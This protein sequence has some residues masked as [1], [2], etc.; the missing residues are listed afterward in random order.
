MKWFGTNDLL[1]KLLDSLEQDKAGDS[2]KTTFAVILGTM[3]L[4]ALF[5]IV[6][7]I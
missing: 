4:V 3:V 2:E 6:V 1:E 5:V 7:I